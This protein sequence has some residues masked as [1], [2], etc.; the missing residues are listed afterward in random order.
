MR[1]R[2][3]LTVA[4]AAG[5][6]VVSEAAGASAAP[7]RGPVA[8]RYLGVFQEKDPTATAADVSR[9]YGVTPASVMWFDSWA[10]GRA[11]PVTEARQLWRRGIM[12]HYTWE[13]WNTALGVNDPAQIHLTDIIDGAWDGYI[14]ARAR[15]F[16][17]VRLPVLVRWGHEFNGNWYPWGIANNNADPSLYVRAYRHVHDLARAAGARNVQWVWAFN[18]G[19][20]PDEAY[21]DPAAAYP[22]D[23]YVDWVG[24]D[25][26]NWGFGPS[27]DPAG[28]HWTSFEAAF[29]TAYAKARSVA[30]KRPVM[31]G[32]FAS[33]EDGGDK[34]RWL[35]DMDTALRSGAFPDL[36]LLTYFDVIKEE[37]WSP[38]SS[39]A[40]RAAFT[41]WVQQRYMKGRGHELARVAAH[42]ARSR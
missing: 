42:Y 16:A 1:R 22:G 8:T 10:S 34:A 31:L 4:A 13:P 39:P 19:S 3:L 25:G 7:V 33:T 37:A 15:E 17:A 12:P 5:A 29:A 20:S 40:A 23:A 28:D 41:A 30:P 35:G 2:S 27:W 9:Q 36:K 38:G 6:L 24:I 14:S 32:E 11:F 26:Y 18:N 21:N